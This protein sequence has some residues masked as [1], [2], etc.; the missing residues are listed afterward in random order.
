LIDPV[1]LVKWVH[2]VS[3]TVLFGTGL[4]TAYYMLLAW[5]SGRPLIAAAVGRMVVR[6]DWIFTLTAGIVQPATGIALIL[7][8]GWD[9][10]SGWLVVTYI[11]YAVAFVCWVPV[12][13][14][15]IQ[16][17]RI[18]AA[19]PDGVPLPEA[20]HRRMRIW[21]LLGWPAFVALLGVFYLMIAKPDLGDFF[22]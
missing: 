22:S 20:Y 1:V 8:E 4:G 18:A 2:V 5:R 3:S 12:L 17:T 7:L 19:L 16:A 10:H 14:L 9:P 11:L 21:F 13:V 15:Q 6:A